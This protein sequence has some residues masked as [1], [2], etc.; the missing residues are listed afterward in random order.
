MKTKTFC[1]ALILWL[2]LSDYC[3]S[4]QSS[5]LQKMHFRLLFLLAGLLWRIK[6]GWCSHDCLL[7]CKCS[8]EQST[9][10]KCYICSTTENT[11]WFLLLLVSFSAMQI[12][13]L[14]LHGIF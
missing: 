8:D 7:V 14:Y 10:T 9:G 3:H 11:N 2:L 12:S 6:R 4:E 1:I 13:G 5:Q